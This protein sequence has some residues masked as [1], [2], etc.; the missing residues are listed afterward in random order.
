MTFKAKTFDVKD[1]ANI[2]KK[3]QYCIKS[4]VESFNS[5]LE[6]K[7]LSGNDSYEPTD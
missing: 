7:M 2:L 3:A 5:K 6:D 4:P 1:V